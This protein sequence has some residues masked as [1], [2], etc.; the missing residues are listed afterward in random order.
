MHMSI[1]ITVHL[2]YNY[3]K[4]MANLFYLYIVDWQCYSVFV[5]LKGVWVVS[6]NENA[7]CLR[8]ATQA[9][10]YLGLCQY[11]CTGHPHVEHI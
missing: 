1:H 2:K 3:M 5:N 10:I 9:A 6:Q 8:S 4:Y 7:M 11:V